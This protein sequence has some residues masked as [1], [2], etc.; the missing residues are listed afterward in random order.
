MLV[1]VIGNLLIL[2]VGEWITHRSTPAGALQYGGGTVLADTTTY[3][4]FW[5]PLGYHFEPGGSDAGYE[6]AMEGFLRDVGGTPYFD[7]LKQYSSDGSGQSFARTT[8][9]GGAVLDSDP[10]PARVGQGRPLMP[11][12]IQPELQ[13]ILKKRGWPSGL[14]SVFL[15]F[16]PDG[17]AA[18][19]TAQPA[20][21]PGMPGAPC[22]AH[23]FI[24]YTPGDIIYADLPADGSRCYRPAGHAAARISAIAS[25]T[26]A[27]S[28]AFMDTLLNPGGDGWTD[29]S[30]KEIAD[31]CDGAPGIPKGTRAGAALVKLHGRPY[32]VAQ[33]WNNARGRC[34]AS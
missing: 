23:G 14:R 17:V 16:V 33:L 20:N 15:L 31:R 1:V 7:I 28:H 21:C 26:L 3:A 32:L 18:C 8:A 10:F 25:G 12:D 22:S 6:R 29:G 11:W 5:R 4:I 27:E 2:G 24:G 9:S 30:G 34:V 19:P 13:K